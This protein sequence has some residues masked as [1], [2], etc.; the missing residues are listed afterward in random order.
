MS[1]S[2]EISAPPGAPAW[3]D[4]TRARRA[5]RRLAR[6]S[7]F[8]YFLAFPITVAA[9]VLVGAAVLARG[10]WELAAA[11]AVLLLLA[12]VLWMIHGVAVGSRVAAVVHAALACGACALLL[13]AD[14]E[15]GGAAGAEHAYRLL[16]GL[17]PGP[18]VDFPPWYR[19]AAVV[20]AV[21]GYAGVVLTG[22]WTAFRDREILRALPPV[23]GGGKK[24]AGGLAGGVRRVLASPRGRR[25][26]LYVGL[27]VAVWATIMVAGLSA[28]VFWMV[29]VPNP[30]PWN[31]PPAVWLALVAAGLV[32]GGANL[33]FVAGRRELARHAAELR[34]RDPRPPVLLIR[35]FDDD[36]IQ[37]GR[38]W[39]WSQL[40]FNMRPYT[41]EEAV[42]DEMSRHGP[43]V[44]F[45]R[46]GERRPPLGAARE[47]VAQDRWR[48]HLEA[49]VAEARVIV[50]VLGGSGGLAWEWE[51][52]LRSG[53]LPRVVLVVPPRSGP[54]IRRRLDLLSAATGHPELAEVLGEGDLSRVLACRFGEVDVD[55]VV[56]CR[57]RDEEAYRI[58]LS[59]L[60]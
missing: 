19:R 14:P 2:G 24:V 33:L 23:S 52:I 1:A 35:S 16:L 51:A 38:R 55:R 59:A 10:V 50:A 37:V 48:E 21:V 44:A 15:V 39:T 12:G 54:E 30:R 57:V 42:A 17:P 3:I 18:S 45:G 22:T 31:L 5:H 49:H 9:P 20:V 56:T 7:R 32:L 11:C 26:A 58:A 28:F 6:A 41:L 13:S 8:G 27:A 34:A 47:Y 40:L 29:T 4:V 46:P 36:R 25:G 43:V 53:S 60:A